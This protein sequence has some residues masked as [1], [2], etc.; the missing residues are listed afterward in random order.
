MTDD[1][2]HRA[3]VAYLAQT[4]SNPER[5]WDQL[6]EWIKES[7]RC[8]VDETRDPLG[9]TRAAGAETQQRTGALD[10]ASGRAVNKAFA[11]RVED[12]DV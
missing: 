12:D 10:Y 3:E 6:P 8:E 9:I 5:S 1:V 11:K 4:G 7:W 2:E